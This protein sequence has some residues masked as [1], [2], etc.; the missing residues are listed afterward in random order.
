MTADART[1]S[2][3]RDG[4]EH[5]G[6][7]SAALRLGPGRLRALLL[8]DKADVRRELRRRVEALV[9]RVVPLPPGLDVLAR[10]HELAASSEAPPEVG[11]LL[12]D[13]GA[14]AWSTVVGSRSTATSRSDS[15]GRSFR[16]RE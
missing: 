15:W 2:L 4:E 9:D 13:A 16:A 1:M 11:A 7:L 3:G 8:A 10:I 14:L 6:K 5:W 12:G